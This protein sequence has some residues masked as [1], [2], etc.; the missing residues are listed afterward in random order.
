MQH[1]TADRH[2]EIFETAQPAPDGQ[3][4][5]Q[6]LGG[7]FMAAVTGIDH[8]A[9]Q[10]ARQKLGRTAVLVAHH[11]YVGAHGGPGGGGINQGLTPGDR[12][13]LYAHVEHIG[14]QP[15]A[16][17]LERGLGTGGRFEEQVDERAALEQ[18]DLLVCGPAQRGIGFG[19]VE[20]GG[21]FGRAKAFDP[22]QMACLQDRGLDRGCH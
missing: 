12:G 8:P 6:G 11:Q 19:Q 13:S 10:L 20:Q 9:V 3:C 17:Q 15:L 16:R 2:G 1:V 18:G 14:A 7:V 4:V 5:Q 21:D 22:K